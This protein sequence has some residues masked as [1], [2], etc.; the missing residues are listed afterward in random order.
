MVLAL[1]LAVIAVLG[2]VFYVVTPPGREK[3]NSTS[4]GAD[5]KLAPADGPLIPTTNAAR[6]VGWPEGR[7]P[8]APPGFT[9]TR[10]AAGLDHP[11]WLYRLPNGDVCAAKPIPGARPSRRS[12][13]RVRAFGL[14]N[15]NGLAI[16]P[17]TSALWTVV[18]E[19]DLS[20]D[21]V[22][23]D[24]LTRVRDGDFYGWR[25]S[26]WAQHVDE[27]VQPQR[28][29]LVAQAPTRRDPQARQPSPQ[30]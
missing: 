26:Y 13:E 8:S 30:R 1:G 16:E 4:V 11:R 19:R 21:D 2:S 3:P 29:D 22:P 10:F 7:T 24:Y 20:G 25:W 6:V 5:P 17:A 12:S 14:R 27:R 9:V 18:N 15:P 23:P 28:P